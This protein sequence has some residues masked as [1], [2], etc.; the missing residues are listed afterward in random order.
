[1]SKFLLLASSLVIGFHAISQND[2]TRINIDEEINA[3]KKEGTE[4]VPAMKVFYS[5]KLIN[6]K[7]V[8]VLRKGVLEFNVTHNFS[9]VGGSRGG[10]QR[11]FGLDEAADVRIGFQVGLSDRFNLVAARAKGAGLIQQQWELGLKWQILKQEAEASGHPF[12]MT[13]FAN[14]V[15]STMPAN[16][17][18]INVPEQE[19]SFEK[20]SD[21]LSQVLQLM[22]ARRFGNVSLQ[23]SPT[24]V[25]RN[26]V[27]QND[28][29]TLF[30]LGAAAR[31]PFSQKLIFIADYFHTFR[32]ANSKG[33]FKTQGVQFYDAI[34]AGFEILTHG[35]V[36]HINFTNA[37]EILENR[38]IP[39]TVTSW[40]KGQFRWGFTISRNFILFRQK[41][42]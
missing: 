18:S 37:T 21:R 8:E 23:I 28:Q 10:I 12:S 5:Q 33:Y 6:A 11:F 1:M 17:V 35:H 32:S 34:G 19:N 24:I 36:F 39:R 4:P 40:G 42:K 16:N 9:D 7:T 15:I 14:N 22:L 41:S 29:N 13:V 20:F 30:A 3:Q 2:T 31:I 38:F 26:F 25:N 27:V